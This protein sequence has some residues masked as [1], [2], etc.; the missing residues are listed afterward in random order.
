MLGFQSI[1]N[2][3]IFTFFEWSRSR[4]QILASDPLAKTGAAEVAKKGRTGEGGRLPNN[5]AA[6]ICSA[7]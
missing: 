4:F 2:F 1:S 6:L 3:E 5:T 7:L